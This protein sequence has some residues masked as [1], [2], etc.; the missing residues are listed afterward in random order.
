MNS[1]QVIKQ[2]K[3]NCA[4]LRLAL[5]HDKFIVDRDNACK[6]THPASLRMAFD[7]NIPDETRLRMFKLRSEAWI[8]QRESENKY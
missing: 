2:G 1:N 7:L 3:I 6:L 8:K 5:E 4:R